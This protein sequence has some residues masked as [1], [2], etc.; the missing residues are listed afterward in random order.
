MVH[1]DERMRREG[2]QARLLL[3]VHDELIVECPSAETETVSRILKEEMENAAS[4]S[5]PLTV[6]VN[7]GHSW[8]EAH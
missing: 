3:Q 5:V 1:V 4:L 8:G 6:E 2:L 7:S